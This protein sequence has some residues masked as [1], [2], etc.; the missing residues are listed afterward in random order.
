MET[1]A[2][3]ERSSKRIK[4]AA[5]LLFLD[6]GYDG[7]TMQ[8]IADASGVNKALLHYYFEGKDKLFLLIFREELAELS[9][10]LATIWREGPLEERPLEERLLEWIDSQLAFLARAPR[11]PLFI[12]AEMSRNPLLVQGL[13]GEFLPSLTLLQPEAD[14]AGPGEGPRLAG[15][16]ELMGSLYS[17]LY[18]PAVAAP[19]I[20]HLL[21]ADSPLL[22]QLL[23]SQGRLAKDLVHERLGG[24][25]RASLS[26]SPFPKSA[27][28]MA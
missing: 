10:S 14:G 6:K 26:D 13:L 22:A 3:N 23:A 19:L 18:F 25:P 17:L 2:Q 4:E 27:G 9:E 15:L 16:V 5:K 7:T 1:E 28:G 21:G 8:A 24:K 20:E 12:I 11:L